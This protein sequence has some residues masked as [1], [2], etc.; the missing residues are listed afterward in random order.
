MDDEHYVSG[1]L[2]YVYPQDVL[3][4]GDLGKERLSNK[5]QLQ[6]QIRL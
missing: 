2:A 3:Q 6:N 1:Q 5:S 4:E